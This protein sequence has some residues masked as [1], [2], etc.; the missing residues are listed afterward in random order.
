M[1]KPEHVFTVHVKTNQPKDEIVSYDAGKKL[2]HVTVKAKPEHNKAN[3]AIIK[4]FK[5]T[6]GIDV[7]IIRGN[8]LKKKT[9]RVVG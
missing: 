3:I 4:L 1:K 2:Y 5:R 8:T 6:C 9:L 7:S